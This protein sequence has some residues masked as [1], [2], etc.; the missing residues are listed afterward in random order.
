[1]IGAEQDPVAGLARQMGADAHDRAPDLDVGLVIMLAQ[2]LPYVRP[3]LLLVGTIAHHRKHRADDHHHREVIAHVG[4]QARALDVALQQEQ[5]DHDARDTQLLVDAAD[6]HGL[7]DALVLASDEIAVQVDVHVVDA[8]ALGKRH[9]HEDVV[10]VESVAWQGETAIAQHLRTVDNRV[11]EDVLGQAKVT[12]VIPGEELLYR[13]HTPVAHD[14]LRV[15]NGILVHV[16]DEHQIERLIERRELVEH[17]HVSVIVEPVIAIHDLEVGAARVLEPR[18][19]RR[20]MAAVLLVDGTYHVRVSG[21]PHLRLF[22]RIVLGR[23]I[24]DDDDLDIVRTIARENRLDAGIHVF[25]R[26]IT[27][28]RVCDELRIHSRLLYTSKH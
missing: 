2:V 6:H 24:I 27:G 7:V 4:A 13:Q 5:V 19:D 10:H 1:M 3:H 17:A 26:V 20:A 14:L 9:V 8:L 28:N 11:H 25:C 21:L 18:H 22:E 15:V 23:P 12:A 16:V